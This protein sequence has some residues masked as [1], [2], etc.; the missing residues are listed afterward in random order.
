MP[1]GPESLRATDLAE[2]RGEEQRIEAR[3]AE[4]HKE[5]GLTDLV[6]TQI[7]FVVGTVWVGTAAKLGADQLFF[8]L[9][10]ILTFYL[11]LAA[12]VI[13]LNRLMPLEGGLYQWAKLGFNEFVGFMVAWDLWVFAILV[14]STIGLTV[15]TNLS[16]ALG[17]GAHWIA[18]SR[19]FITVFSGALVGVL[20]GVATRGL[21]LGKWVHNAGGVLLSL[22]FLTLIVLPFVSRWSGRIPVFHPIVFAV[23]DLSLSD[24]ERLIRSLNIFSKLALGALTGFEYVAILAGECKTPARNIGRSVVIAAPI[25]ALMFILGTAS[26]LAFVRPE[27][28][29]LI[30]PIAQ[31]LSRGFGMFGVLAGGVVSLVIFALIGRLV[32]LMSIYLTANA[33]LPMVA[34]WDDLLPAWFTR[35]H[36]RYKTPVHSIVL[37]GATALGFGLL[38]I[39][40]VGMQEANQLLDNAAGIFYAS[41]YVV[42]FAIPLFASSRI[43]ARTPWWLHLACVSGA[44]VS[45]LYIALTI[46]PIVQ[47][48][49]RLAFAAKLIGV[50]LVLNLI[51]ASLCLAGRRRQRAAGARA[52]V[53]GA[54]LAAGLAGAGTDAGA[55]KRAVPAARPVATPA[56]PSPL[57]L[58]DAGWRLVGPFRAGWAT[59]VAG[60]EGEPA[61]FYFGGAGGGVWKTVDAGRTW[62]GLMQDQR[63]AAIG[64]LAVAPSD[65][66]ILYAGTGQADARYDIMAG[67]GVYRSGDG[68]ESWTRA[69]LTGSRHIGAILVDPKNADRVL[70]AALGHVFGSG[71][72]RGVYRSRDG[73][74]NWQCVLPAPDSVGAVDLAWDPLRPEVVYASTWQLRLHPWLDY[75][76]PQGGRGS[77]IWRSDDGGEHWRRL[78]GG[79]PVGRIG[80]IGLA[81][82]RGSGGR[83]VY[84][85]IQAFPQ[86]FAVTDTSASRPRTGLYHSGDGGATWQLVNADGSIGSSYFGRLVVSPADSS[87]LYLMGR[88]I[89]ISRDGGRHFEVWRGSPGGDD[90]HALWI[91]ATDP[92]RMIAGSDQG[93]G[94][95][96]NGGG[97]W[98]SWYNQP[99]G[100]FYHLAADEQFPYHIFSGQQDNGTIEI[101]SRGPY[102]VIEERDWHPVGGDERDYMVPKPGDPRTVFG[103]GLG[104]TVSRFD[105]WTRQSADASAWPLG[106]YGADP[107]TVRYRYTWI[108]PLVIS[109]LAP[110]AMYLGAQVLFRSRDDGQSWDVVSP[111]LSGKRAGGAPC[112]DPSALEARACGYGVI[113]SIAPSPRDT[114]VLW[115]GTDDGL[116]KRTEDGGAHWLDVTPAD[117]PPWGIVSSIDLSP[118]DSATAYLAVDTHRLDR[119]TP[120]AFRTTDNGRTWRSITRGIPADEF[121]AVVRCD[122]KQRGLL[123]AGT[124]RSVYVSF[125]DGE[126]WQPL[127]TGLPTSW[128]RDLLAHHDDLIVASQGRGIWVLDDLS[129][130]RG[131]AA[132]AAREPVHLFAPAAAVRLRTSENRDTPPPPETPLGQN[133]PTG[134]VLD[135]W[136]AN[137]AGGPVTLTIADE[138]GREV[139]RFRSDDPPESLK[140]D[141]YYESG[142]LR[143]ARALLGSAGM[144]RFVWDLRYPRPAAR[145]FRSSIAAVRGGGTPALPLGPFVLPGRYTVTLSAGGATRSRPLEVRLDPRVRV[146]DGD[147]EAQLRLSQAIDST[148]Q[149][150]W[151]AH[152]AITRARSTRGNALDPALRDSLAAL[153]GPGPASL[154]AVT[155]QLTQLA[156]SAQSADSAPSRGLEEAF[157][158]CEARTTGLITRWRSVEAALPPG[159]GIPRQAP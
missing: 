24:P 19:L 119:F 96:L 142:W 90:Y 139:R 36:P 75:F 55:A 98:S 134:A 93:A 2:V 49:S 135:Y 43:G 126:N 91:D 20:V 136:L 85:C 6:L 131:L 105:E 158:A 46:V 53:L 27:D 45:L 56:A 120:L 94:V 48:E 144:H 18:G 31:V 12:V 13:H 79:L 17:P 78:A 116:V 156:I 51:G 150:A 72:E 69:G 11:P 127:A 14:M 143:P 99:T 107:T 114:S 52:L 145:S 106:S 42:L 102:G 4:F 10:A 41:T 122:R 88:S 29:D 77:G 117:L 159:S 16:Y 141:V 60:I 89:R 148:L 37:V 133:P 80:R 124:D 125:D 54:A 112:Q 1:D 95:S 92:A 8:W 121:V 87:T 152:D 61:T 108:T 67:D 155:D 28:V 73:G 82:A 103:S 58:P 110:H 47:V 9:L 23:P 5:L 3:S 111:D 129:P 7:V 64:A 40:G 21:G 34:G 44:L 123:Y 154:T 71:G 39:A 59:A 146:A 15:V 83:N 147:L 32:A 140:V 62:R 101:A 113:F 153:A 26:V 57:P 130:L 151:A 38:G 104:G 86:G 66:R 81:V 132:G 100:Q 68:G 50:A 109:P 35:L 74:R 118:L 30:G 84:A 33:R 76:M 149:R 70:V 25:I 115:V 138:Q 97:T 22:T 63:S 137:P 157:H 65:P 128:M